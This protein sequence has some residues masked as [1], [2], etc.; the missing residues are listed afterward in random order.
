ME[1]RRDGGADHRGE[2]VVT[3]A[4]ERAVQVLERL[5]LGQLVGADAGQEFGD[6]E[7]TEVSG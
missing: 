6:G 3:L 4:T 7:A 1:A 2:V 5:P